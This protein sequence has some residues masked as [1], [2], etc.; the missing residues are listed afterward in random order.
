MYYGS[1]SCSSA[2]QASER[3]ILMTFY[4]GLN[5]DKWLSNF[6]WGTDTGICTWFGVT[7]DQD[8]SVIELKLASNQIVSTKD[9]LGAL[10]QIFELPNLQ[11]SP[12]L[13]I[14]L[15]SPLSLA[16]TH[17]G[18]DSNLGPGLEGQLRLS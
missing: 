11:V 9:Q 10:A 18:F 2:A 12:S 3:D 13:S 7:C 6:N 15:L 8:L 16:C 1:T 14:L 5:G 17:T 4:D